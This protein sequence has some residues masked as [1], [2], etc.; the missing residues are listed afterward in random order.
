MNT[1]TAQEAREHWAETVEDALFK[2]TQT[3]I[4]SRNKPISVVV[5]VPW[6]ERA[7][8]VVPPGGEM[9][10]MG[11]RDGRESLRARLDHARRGGHTTITRYGQPAAVLTP[12]EWFVRADRALSQATS[13]PA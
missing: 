3:T 10:E 12:H 6:W 11:V 2:G 4:T 5:P 13:D 7:V 9:V 1:R 8:A